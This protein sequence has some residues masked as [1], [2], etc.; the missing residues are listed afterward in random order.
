MRVKEAWAQFNASPYKRKKLLNKIFIHFL[1]ALLVFLVAAPVLWAIIASTQTPGEIYSYPPKLTFGSATVRNFYL[2][3]TRFNIGRGMLNSLIIAVIVTVCK[4]IISLMAALAL[5]YFDFPMKPAIFFLIL[6]TLLIPIPVVIIPLF[7]LVSDLGWANS[8]WALT[9]PFFASAT[10]TFLFRQHF[11]SI[12]T[13]IAEAAKID[14][15]GPI[16]FLVQILT[17]MSL[18]TIGA[19][20]VIQFVYMWNQYL[21]PL[22]IISDKRYQVV[23]VSMRQLTTTG[24]E[25]MIDWGIAMAGALIALVPPLIIF[26]L[27]QEQFMRGFALSEDK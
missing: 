1:I 7:E 17:P 27:L 15:A 8:Y 11:M 9:L 6:L 4:I 16:R 14:G 5:V 21:W 19:F 25:Q 22:L 10:G 13:S 23:Q 18:N 3:W 20:C 12:P 26:F 2:A 24:P